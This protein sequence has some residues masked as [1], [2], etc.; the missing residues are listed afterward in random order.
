[1][2]HS[3]VSPIGNPLSLPIRNTVLDNFPLLRCHRIVYPAKV[4][5][6]HFDGPSGRK[7]RPRPKN[8]ASVCR[9]RSS[10]M[11]Y[12]TRTK[13][14]KHIREYVFSSVH[15]SLKC[16]RVSLEIKWIINIV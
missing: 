15:Y 9:G 5:Y 3:I 4:I 14:H 12:G 13:E 1:M 8:S 11:A 6:D 16:F 7:N 10:S 2:L